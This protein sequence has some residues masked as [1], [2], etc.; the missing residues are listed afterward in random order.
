MEIMTVCSGQDRFILLDRITQVRENTIVAEKT[1]AETPV[2]LGI[3]SLAQ[4]GAMHVR[5]A[6]Q[7]SRHAMLLIIE[8]CGFNPGLELNGTYQL[9]GKRTSRSQYAYGYHLTALKNDQ[10]VING[11]FLFATIA[12][13]D[14]FDQNRLQSHYE[15]L[16]TCLQ[17]DIMTD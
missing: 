1:F 10:I 3:E 16:F 9:K 11:Q 15:R 2:W 13:D 17:S 12:Y 6:N 8:E 4:L 5:Y 14:R 7:F